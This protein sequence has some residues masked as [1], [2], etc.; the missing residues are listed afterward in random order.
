M[1][2]LGTAAV[3]AAVGTGVGPARRVVARGTA[4]CPVADR[5]R[6][7]AGGTR[8]PR[9]CR[10][11]RSPSCPARWPPWTGPSRCG[12]SPRRAAAAPSCTPGSP[13]A[14]LSDKFPMGAVLTK[15]LTL[16]G[17]QQHGQRFVPMILERMAAGGIVT[18]HLATH[19]LPL[20]EGPR[21]YELFKTKQ[22]DCVRAVFRPGEQPVPAPVL[23]RSQLP[24]GAENHG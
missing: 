13:H 3:L 5:P 19:V 4:C 20:G 12:S 24:R 22:D 1:T 16:R 10:W 9:T 23:L 15:G 18:E 7:P 21:G 2:R 11:S 17:A 6:R 8:S 14:A